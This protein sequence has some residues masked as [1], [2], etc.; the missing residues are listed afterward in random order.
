MRGYDWDDE[1]QDEIA[2]NIG[3]WLEQSARGEDPPVS[4][5]SG[6]CQ[7]ET[8]CDICRYLSGSLWC[9]CLNALR[10]R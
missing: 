4:T 5:T 10:I 9:S 7:V 6:A 2:D 3:D 1:V 8:H